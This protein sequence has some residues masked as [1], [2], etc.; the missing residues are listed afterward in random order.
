MGCLSGVHRLG[1]LGVGVQEASAPG[2]NFLTATEC[3]FFLFFFSRNSSYS[4]TPTQPLSKQAPGILH[5]SAWVSLKNLA[6]DPVAWA[7][8]Y[9]RPGPQ[10]SDVLVPALVPENLLSL[11]IFF[12]YLTFQCPLQFLVSDLHICWNTIGCSLCSSEDQLGV[13]PVPKGK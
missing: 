11:S 12:H 13:S 5:S 2:E 1:A 9:R 7:W 4:S 8:G 3:L 6:A 10:A